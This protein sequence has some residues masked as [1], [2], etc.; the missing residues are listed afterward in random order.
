M[1]TRSIFPLALPGKQEHMQQMFTYATT[2]FPP[3]YNP[4][5]SP[6]LSHTHARQT[7]LSTPLSLDLTLETIARD[8]IRDIVIIIIGLLLPILALLLLHALIALRQLPQRCQ[9][10]RPQLVQDPRHQL[11]QFFV[12]ACAVNRECVGGDG[13]VHCVLGLVGVG[14]GWGG[15]GFWGGGGL[16]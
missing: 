15:V 9:R 4:P 5:P 16:G 1:T 14:G 13:R 11:R 8:Q 7:P 3:T 2:T 10:V 12:F 6:S